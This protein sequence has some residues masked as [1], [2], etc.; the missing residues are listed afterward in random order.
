MKPRLKPGLSGAE[1][2]LDDTQQQTH[3][4]QF[5]HSAI[6]A[7]LFNGSSQNNFR[8]NLKKFSLFLL[9]IEAA[10]RRL[11]FHLRQPRRQL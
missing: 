5:C 11:L 2:H 9:T 7:Y 3:L 1:K 4:S 10:Q 8:V 6:A